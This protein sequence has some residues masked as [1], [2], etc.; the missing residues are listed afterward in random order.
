[1]ARARATAE[2]SV[3]QCREVAAWIEV[4][5]ESLPPAVRAFLEFHQVYLAAGEGD[6]MRRAAATAWRSLLRALHLTPSSEKRR[7]SGSPLAGIP[8]A[9]CLCAKDE[10]ERLEAHLARC[11]LLSGWHRG[12]KKRHDDHFK[13]LQK[14]LAKMPKEKSEAAQAAEE[15]PSIDEIVIE[16]TDEER[17]QDEAAA[18]RFIEHLT[19][20]GGADPALRPVAETLMPGGA[21]LVQEEHVPVP[22]LVPE[23]LADAQVVETLHEPR[24]RYDFA[25][26]VKRIELEVEKKILVGSDGERH[27]IAG[28]TSEYGP[29]RFQ[30]TWDA[31][32]T[33]TWLTG[34]FAMPF[35]RLGTLLSSQDKRFTAGGLARMLHYVAQR[36]VPIYLELGAQLSRSD[37]LAGDDTSCRVLEVSSYFEWARAN[38][39]E[40]RSQAPPWSGYATPSIADQSLRQCQKLTEARIRR[41]D[42]GDRAAVR[43]I[44]E[45][46]SLGMLIGKRFPFESMRRNGDGRKEATHHGRHRAKR[47]LRPGEPHRFL[48][49]P[50]RELRQPLRID[51]RESR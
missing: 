51:S 30:V 8:G 4:N 29:P 43:A 13:R 5:G 47:G 45:V 7:S 10:R 50:P 44:E 42:D 1:M 19:S 36:F 20:G 26:A 28:S 32:S 48:S 41:R 16:L 31:L 24:V 6:P 39:A 21:A 49:Q 15:I 34:Q 23:G 27:V 25:V 22:A 40:A 17:A 2:L 18:D 12:L 11:R 9:D 3:E 33:L 37:Y 14:R 38:P 35:N 46:P